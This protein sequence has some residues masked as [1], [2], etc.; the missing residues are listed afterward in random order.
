MGSFRLVRLVARVCL[1]FAVLAGCA[2]STVPYVYKAGEFNRAS[3]D[4]GKV[5]TDITS[6]TICYG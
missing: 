2:G 3:P 1:P 5:P 4:F 6:V